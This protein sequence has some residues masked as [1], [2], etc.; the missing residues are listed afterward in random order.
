MIKTAV[1]IVKI[2]F[3][4]KRRYKPLFLLIFGLLGFLFVLF[5]FYFFRRIFLNL[6]Y[7][8]G[9]PEQ[10][11]LIVSSKLMGLVFLTTYT[12]IIFSSSISA[13]SSIYL[14]DDL[15]FL[16]S[17]P[18]K[19]MS[20]II[21]GLI[22]T[23]FTSS[24]MVVMLLFPI[25]LSFYSAKCEN[26]FL[27]L[28][29]FLSFILFLIP[30]LSIGSAITVV[31]ARF[32][33]AKRLHQFLTIMGIALL[34]LLV[35]FIRV[36]KPERLLNP[37]ESPKIEKIL[38]SVNL[39]N[40]SV[41]PSTWMS[42]AV[43][44]AGAGE[45]DRFINYS[46]KLALL[47]LLS[48]LILCIFL[49]I[50][51]AKGFLFSKERIGSI[52][53]ETR[54]FF[55]RTIFSA[56]K[57]FPI[58]NEARGVLYKDTLIF[59]R[60]A[61]EWGQVFILLALV[62]VYIFNINYLP[63][64]IESMKVIVALLNYA[65]LGFIVASVAA[66]FTFTSIGSE[67][68]TFFMTK[69]MPLKTSV[70]VLTKFVFSSSPIIVFSI[71]IFIVSGIILDLKGLSFWYFLFATFVTSTVFCS[72]AIFMGSIN[73]EF[74]EKNPT[75]ML[76]TAEGFEYMFFSLGFVAYAIIVSAKPIYLTYFE[77]I[78]K[79]AENPSKSFAISS[80]LLALPLILVP[81]FLHLSKSRISG[82]E[83]K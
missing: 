44:T 57:R 76:I 42:R 51:Y 53:F 15:D 10:A 62:I 32:F 67:G 69:T 8:K 5:D 46:F 39:P 77:Q 13:L 68:K 45:V 60:S 47:A 30:P 70:F 22:D 54:S 80:I 63:K 81:V 41:L 25:M 38:S 3:F 74:N 37:R 78:I 48:L 49:K 55:E 28:A 71:G 24:I 66:R 56:L 64:D 58:S 9:V 50:F 34:S 26:F 72:F 65:T 31:L 21:K 23:F 14:D 36:S 11:I 2:D 20:V 12:M 33:P 83:Q 17:L 59:F 27:P 4:S 16:F 82:M 29:S 19:R 18:V 79:R 61:T 1:K 35:I 75:K 73:P 52:A 40:E 6:F 43:V 7:I